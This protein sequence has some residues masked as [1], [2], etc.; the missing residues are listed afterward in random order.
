M[1]VR[2][3]SSSEDVT[4]VLTEDQ[5]LYA[6]FLERFLCKVSKQEEAVGK[7]EKQRTF[8][9]ATVKRYYVAP[10]IDSPEPAPHTWREYRRNNAKV[11]EF[12][13]DPTVVAFENKVKEWKKKKKR[14]A[15]EQ[16]LKDT[17]AYVK[18]ETQFLDNSALDDRIQYSELRG[19]KRHEYTEKEIWDTVTRHGQT[20]TCEE[21]IGL[22]GTTHV[23]MYTLG[24]D[25]VVDYRE[26]VRPIEHE[27]NLQGV[28]NNYCP[29]HSQVVFHGREK[30]F[31][32][33]DPV[34]FELEALG[35]L[36]WPG[37]LHGVQPD[38]SGVDGAVGAVGAGGV[39]LESLQEG[40]GLAGQAAGQ[41]KGGKV[42]GKGKGKGRASLVEKEGGSLVESGGIDDVDVDLE[43]EE[44]V[45]VL[46]SS[47]DQINVDSSGSI[48]PFSLSSQRD[49]R[50]MRSEGETYDDDTLYVSD[51]ATDN[52][53][54][55]NYDSS[56]SDS[57]AVWSDSE[58]GEELFD[59]FE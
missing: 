13:N 27:L 45:D 47:L 57:A 52:E 3:P 55:M 18:Q 1:Y 56:S 53:D 24:M 4:E 10:A 33:H 42:K 38:D 51:D 25:E 40:G 5:I 32:N 31:S 37:E 15:V 48:D 59:D 20:P 22:Q 23:Q 26:T 17:E 19:W 49:S 12:L 39:N 6:E 58:E 11:D 34:L 7:P 29:E 16:S 21:V 8:S 30:N 35:R 36:K 2:D 43:A 50:E 14:R 41:M 54:N 44:G 9:P 46:S 28:F